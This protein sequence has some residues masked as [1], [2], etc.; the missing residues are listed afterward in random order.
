MT[1]FKA[2]GTYSGSRWKELVSNPS[3]AAWFCEPGLSAVTWYSLSPV[4]SPLLPSLSHPSSPLPSPPLKRTSWLLGRVRLEA[5]SFYKRLLSSVLKD[6][7]SNAGLFCLL[8][9]PRPE[10]RPMIAPFHVSGLALISQGETDLLFQ[11]LND[12]HYMRIFLKGLECRCL[13]FGI[14][15]AK[16]TQGYNPELPI[17]Q[18]PALH[19]FIKHVCHVI[20][21]VPGDGDSCGR[22]QLLAG[23]AMTGRIRGSLE[24]PMTNTGPW[25]TGWAGRSCL[26]G[27]HV[28]TEHRPSLHDVPRLT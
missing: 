23:A 3:S 27:A 1:A 17:L 6:P 10:E 25:S 15:R 9:K 28:R 2:W 19:I 21:L 26:C 4:T 5:T 16:E 13:L 20:K 7:E 8:R 12:S 24:Q 11:K 22:E 14:G 18:G